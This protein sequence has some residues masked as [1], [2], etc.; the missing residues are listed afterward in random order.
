MLRDLDVD[1]DRPHGLGRVDEVVDGRL[2]DALERRMQWVR[3]IGHAALIHLAA[4]LWEAAANRDRRDVRRT[5]WVQLHED[6]QRTCAP[7]LSGHILDPRA[8]DTAGVVAVTVEGVRRPIGARGLALAGDDLRRRGARGVE[9][10]DASAAGVARA[11]G[12]EQHPAGAVGDTRVDVCAAVPGRLAAA[13]LQVHRPPRSIEARLQR[14]VEH[15]LIVKAQPIPALASARRTRR[16]CRRRRRDR[17]GRRARVVAELGGLRASRDRAADSRR[18]RLETSLEIHARRQ[19][20]REPLGHGV[21]GRRCDRSLLFNLR[22][23]AAGLGTE[24]RHLDVRVVCCC[25]THSRRRQCHGRRSHWGEERVTAAGTTPRSFLFTARRAAQAF[26]QVASG[27]EGGALVE[28]RPLREVQARHGFPV[29]HER[30]EQRDSRVVVLA[31]QHLRGA[32]LG[33]F[34][35]L[36]RRRQAI[37]E[38]PDRMSVL[39]GHDALRGGLGDDMRNVCGLVRD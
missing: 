3:V 5:G 26:I 39:R 22:A 38:D 31:V 17:H 2:V 20:V 30:I 9:L 14:G 36:P 15:L 27:A 7:V 35:E 10:G 12:D 11:G 32:L 29:R 16:R 28:E 33:A 25:R 8:G 6:A 4:R 21:R 34:G 18:P 1:D 13:S 19:R 23:N 24:L 37:H